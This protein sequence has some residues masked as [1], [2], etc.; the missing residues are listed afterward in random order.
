[1]VFWKAISCRQ[2]KFRCHYGFHAIIQKKT[3]TS[4]GAGLALN[5]DMADNALDFDVA[6]SV[7]DYFQISI[8]EMD[9]IIDE[10]N[11]AVIQWFGIAKTIGINNNDI[12]YMA[13]AFK[14]N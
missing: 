11:S 8:K 13:S 14:I 9:Q 6:K 5:I 3:S 7:G 12:D 10:V 1:M 4:F 2:R